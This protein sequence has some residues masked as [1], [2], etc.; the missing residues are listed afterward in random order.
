MSELVFV[1]LGSIQAICAGF[2]FA[3][4]QFAR[5]AKRSRDVLKLDAETQL[6]ALRKAASFF[7]ESHNELIKN[8]AEQALTLE[9]LTAEVA[10][11][12]LRR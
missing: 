10:G 4:L 12:A 5:S 6:V 11:R 9:R 7:S 2:A 1:L 3:C 8:Q